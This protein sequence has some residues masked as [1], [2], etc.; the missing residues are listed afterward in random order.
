[1]TALKCLHSVC[2]GDCVFENFGKHTSYLLSNNVQVVWLFLRLSAIRGGR[3]I[4]GCRTITWIVSG[5]GVTRVVSG[6]WVV[7]SQTLSWR[8]VRTIWWATFWAI[9]RWTITARNLTILLLLSSFSLARS[10]LYRRKNRGEFGKHVSGEC[11]SKLSHGWPVER[12]KV[13]QLIELLEAATV[14]KILIKTIRNSTY[15]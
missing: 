1:M 10:C 2:V 7:L 4:V 13:G 15:W 8:R 6:L 12:G 11:A 3:T 14:T 9:C 5:R